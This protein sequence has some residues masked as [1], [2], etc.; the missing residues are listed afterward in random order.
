MFNIKKV[1][2]LEKEIIELQKERTNTFAITAENYKLKEEDTKL[3]TENAELKGKIR[4]QTEA[5]LY[6][7]SAKIQKE[8][9]EGKKVDELQKDRDYQLALQ[10]SLAQ[11]QQQSYNP[12]SGLSAILGGAFGRPMG[13]Y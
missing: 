9:L 1:E 4:T 7:I 10:A 3:K 13:W 12:Y 11:Q 5:D 8:L 2:R 6:F